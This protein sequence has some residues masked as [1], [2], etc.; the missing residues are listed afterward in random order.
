MPLVSLLLIGMVKELYEDRKRK[1]YDR[2][3]NNRHVLIL[4]SHQVLSC[5]WEEVAVGNVVRVNRGDSIPADMILLVSSEPDGKCFLNTEQL[6]GEGNLKLR[7]ALPYTQRT[8]HANES[9]LFGFEAQCLVEAPNADLYSFCGKFTVPSIGAVLSVS[10]ENLLLKGTILQNIDHI[11]GFVVYAG[12]NCKVHKNLRSVPLKTSPSQSLVNGE[13]YKLLFILGLMV[14]IHTIAYYR[15]RKILRST[16]FTGSKDSLAVWEVFCKALLLYHPIVPISL[17][18]TLELIKVFQS[19]FIEWDRDMMNVTACASEKDAN[20][21][22]VQRPKVVCSDLMDCL[23]QINLICTDKTGTL[24]N[25]TMVFKKCIIHRE[26]HTLQWECDFLRIAASYSVN[27]PVRQFIRSILLCNSVFPE[28]QS[29]S[30]NSWNYMSTSSEEQC[31]IEYLSKCNVKL[32]HRCPQEV[33]VKVA[34]FPVESF[35][36]LYTIEFMSERKKMTVVVQDT[37]TDSIYVYSKGAD[38]A[39]LPC[40]TQN[41]LQ[42]LETVQNSV[43]EFSREGLRSLCF[44]YKQISQETFDSWMHQLEA[45]NSPDKLTIYAQIEQEMQPLGAVGMEDG[46]QEGVPQTIEN[47]STAGITFWM[48][49]GD[50]R[51]IAIDVARLSG[52]INQSTKIVHLSHTKNH[53]ETC[54]FLVNSLNASKEP[55]VCL[56]VEGKQFEE[57]RTNSSLLLGPFIEYAL[58]CKSLILYRATPLHKSELVAAVK[59]LRPSVNILAIGDGANDVSMLREAHVGIGLVGK[60]GT[61]ASKSSDFSI[62]LFR[63]LQKLLLVHGSWAYHRF[64][65]VILFIFYKS[66]VVYYTQF[67]YAFDSGFSGS[68]LFNHPDMIFY[69]IFY[70]AAPPLV[71]G[72]VEQFLPQNLLLANPK[73]YKLGLSCRFFSKWSFWGAFLN[74]VYHSAFTFFS[75]RYLLKRDLLLGNLSFGGKAFFGGMLFF[76]Q[77]VTVSM[78][79]ALSTSTWNFFTFIGIFGNIGLYCVVGPIFGLLFTKGLFKQMFATEVFYLLVFAVPMMALLKDLMWKYLK[80]VYIPTSYHIALKGD[81][82]VMIE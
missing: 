42:A 22:A 63:H 2:E 76:V 35:S 48:L 29:G 82:K 62:L 4:G 15:T 52:I 81:K 9:G 12:A 55:K 18:I 50:K 73:L 23:G 26:L 17:S 56:L 77:L 78:K 51:D 14:V 24:T 75:L 19:A 27:E 66:T 65:K 53:N 80:K 47:L 7:F 8:F 57:I 41:D 40:C 68:S 67:L 74:G 32:L 5:R 33:R 31:M 20:Y 10:G 44:S 3:T 30:S 72:I 70:T 61:Q 59:K 38:C 60:E 36:T 34:E 45:A 39:I 71:L 64:S 21:C 25:N 16:L 13:V 54:I 49:T 11:Y 58:Q 28:L 69:N 46:L 1:A 6:D 43:E 79:A 37:T